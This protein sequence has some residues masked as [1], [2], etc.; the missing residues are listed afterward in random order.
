MILK[1]KQQTE[2]IARTKERIEQWRQHWDGKMFREYFDV[3]RDMAD[4]KLPAKILA[5]LKSDPDYVYKAKLVPRIIPDSI[6]YMKAISSNALFNRNM[7]FD[8]AGLRGESPQ[9]AENANNLVSY[10]FDITKFKIVAEQIIEDMCEVGIGFGERYHFRDL[11][12][13]PTYDVNGNFLRNRFD[14]IYEG[15]SIRRLKPEM[16]YLNPDCTHPSEEP[17]YTKLMVTTIGKLRLGMLGNGIYSEYSKNVQLI[18]PGDYD[19][20]FVSNNQQNQEHKPDG[21]NIYKDDQ[22][23]PV[24]YAENWY[25]IALNPGEV[26]IICCIGIANYNTKPYIVRYDIDPMQTGFSPLVIA[27]IY[28][29]NDRMV[30]ESIS[31]KLYAYLLEKYF[32][33]NQRIDL[34]NLAKDVTG[35]IF[36]SGQLFDMDSMVMRR[37]RI[38]QS[39]TGMPS[40]FKNIQLDTSP[41]PHLLE[42]EMIID[43]DVEKTLAVNR[44]SMGQSPMRR[45]TATALS[46]V[47]ENSQIMSNYPLKQIEDSLIKPVASDFLIHSQ[48]LMPEEFKIRV[49]GKNNV[50]MYPLMT[51]KDILGVYDVKCYASSEILTKAVKQAMMNNFVQIWMANPHVRIDWQALAKESLILTEIPAAD[52]FVIDKTVDQAYAERE[53]SLLDNG[54]PL[55][56]IEQDF[57]EAHIPIHL[58]GKE[59]VDQMKNAILSAVYEKHIMEH[60]QMYQLE[61]GQINLGAGQ[62]PVATNQQQ[63]LRNVN[64]D[65]QT[66]PLG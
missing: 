6:Q 11:R 18:K 25:R 14:L 19:P 48:I 60:Q 27:R 16:V 2:L 53:N 33:R 59:Q 52:R 66:G 44:V 23:F 30:G 58:Q 24:L 36:A 41:I 15:P 3:W 21:T 12:P 42:E 39:R 34:V 50:W 7:I 57:H 10:E 8:F 38:I 20:M 54:I 64:S 22:D 4:G 46:I 40:D 13:A 1:P 32:K 9:S 45:E 61:K 28:P 51:R 37:K 56:A 26:P 5:K 62:L 17:E 65:M 55:H 35:L 31:Q 63:M 29:R 47:N 49:L 43:Q